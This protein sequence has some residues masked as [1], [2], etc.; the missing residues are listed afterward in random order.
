V[1]SAW[2]AF[3]VDDDDGEPPDPL[4]AELHR[5]RR[6]RRVLVVAAV[7]GILAGVA[8]GIGFVL[9]AFGTAA[10]SPI[11]GRNPGLLIFFIGPPAVIMALGYAI[12]AAARRWGP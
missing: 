6:Y 1:R 5:E 12:F 3:E 4:I 9:G 8:T 2:Q 11:G 7:I 10:M